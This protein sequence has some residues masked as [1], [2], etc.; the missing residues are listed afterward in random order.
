MTTRVKLVTGNDATL[1]VERLER[2]LATLPDGAEVLGVDFDT[3][4]TDGGGVHYSA[5]I[6]ADSAVPWD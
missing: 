4:A 5:L 2:A 1:F 6:R 3:C